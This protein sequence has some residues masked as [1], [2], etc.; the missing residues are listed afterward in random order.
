MFDIDHQTVDI[1][2]HTY[3][4]IYIYTCIYRQRDRAQD[5][6]MIVPSNRLIAGFGSDKKKQADTQ[7]RPHVMRKLCKEAYYRLRQS[8][9]ID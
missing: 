2:T 9:S 8:F 3:I 6:Q 4:C 7:I 1:N 5:K